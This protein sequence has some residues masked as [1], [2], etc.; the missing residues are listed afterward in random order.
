[1]AALREG[2]WSMESGIWLRTNRFGACGFRCCSE[3]P[4]SARLGLGASSIGG[5]LVVG[6]LGFFGWETVA[7]YLLSVI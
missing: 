3:S 4:S 1:M 6:K 7:R 2:S 5:E